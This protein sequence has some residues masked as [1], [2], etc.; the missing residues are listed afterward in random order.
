MK[1]FF[2]RKFFATCADIA[3]GSG[4]AEEIRV[5]ALPDQMCRLVKTP[6]LH[7]ADTGLACALPG[8]DDAAL[9]KDRGALGQ[10][11]ETF[12]F[13]LGLRA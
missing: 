2:L 3:P 10:L 11:P 6:K 4:G 1:R 13:Q 8:M 9:A 7:I 12:V 5:A